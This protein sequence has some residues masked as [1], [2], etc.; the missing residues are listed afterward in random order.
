MSRPIHVE[1]SVTVACPPDVV[2]WAVADYGRDTGTGVPIGCRRWIKIA[3][4]LPASRS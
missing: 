3:R 2:W 4:S 1:E